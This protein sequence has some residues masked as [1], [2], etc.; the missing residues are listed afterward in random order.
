ML[1]LSLHLFIK[2]HADDLI[3]TIVIFYLRLLLAVKP[4]YYI[5]N[6]LV[7]ILRLDK[8]GSAAAE[9]DVKYVRASVLIAAKMK[10]KTMNY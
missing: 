1:K 3:K 5:R 8:C 10:I 6:D 7:L 4:L 9:S 2:H